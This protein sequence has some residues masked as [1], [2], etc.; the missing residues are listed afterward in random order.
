METAFSTRHH[1]LLLLTNILVLLLKNLWTILICYRYLHSR[2]S[3]Q[4]K[5]QFYYRNDTVEP[6]TVIHVISAYV[7]PSAIQPMGS[8]QVIKWICFSYSMKLDNAEGGRPFWCAWAG[9]SQCPWHSLKRSD[10]ASSALFLYNLPR[11]S[12]S[13]SLGPRTLKSPSHCVS[14]LAWVYCWTSVDTASI[15][16][17]IIITHVSW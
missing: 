7:C 8:V 4:I 1:K 15:C 13:D 14:W 10:A 11:A 12:A 17:W 2:N 16:Y 3:H 5:Q 6:K 9:R